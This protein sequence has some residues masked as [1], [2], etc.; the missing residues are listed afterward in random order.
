M[1]LHDRRIEMAKKKK[2]TLPGKGK[3]AVRVNS[4]MSQKELASAFFNKTFQ[5]E[6]ATGGKARQAAQAMRT[7]RGPQKMVNPGTKVDLRTNQKFRKK[8]KKK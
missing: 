4:K 2:V 7:V 3:R 5:G 1:D 8:A 6:A